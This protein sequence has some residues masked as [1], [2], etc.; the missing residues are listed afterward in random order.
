MAEKE[1][2]ILAKI[3]DR[4]GMSHPPFHNLG[5]IPFCLGTFLA[6]RLDRAFDLATF[7]LG[8]IGIVLVMLATR[9]AGEHIARSSDE[10]STH[11]APNFSA[12]SDRTL[13]DRIFRTPGPL[14]TGAAALAGA[15]LTGALL[16]FALK[17]GPFTLLLGCI[18]A[19]PGLFYATRPAHR[20]DYG[21]GE[22]LI[23]FCY[24]WLPIAAAFY[25]QR[26]YITPCIHWMALPLGL[27]IFN[28]VLLS[29]FSEQ[30]ANPADVRKDLLTRLGAEKGMALYCGISILCWLSMYGSLHAGI[31]RKALYIYLPVM[32]LSAV[33]SLMMARKRYGNLFMLEILGGLNIAVHL[34]TAAAYFLAFL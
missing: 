32:A 19:L 5:V 2:D 3:A 21:L 34:G 14:R 16:Q 31:P 15:F 12:N 6:W 17:T 8:I 28:V 24:G 4:L 11:R 25:I 29:E 33:I 26:G 30:A 10:R 13:P 20:A 22:V 18:G 9:H 7:A 27:S 1:T 23:A